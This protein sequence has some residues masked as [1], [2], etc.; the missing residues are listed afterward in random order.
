[1]GFELLELTGLLELIFPEL[2]NLKGGWR[3][4]QARP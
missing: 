1:M 2:H 3:S 4:G